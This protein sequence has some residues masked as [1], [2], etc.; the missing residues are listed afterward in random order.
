MSCSMELVEMMDAIELEEKQELQ[1]TKKLLSYYQKLCKIRT[2]EIKRLEE[3]NE[4]YF[5]AWKYYWSNGMMGKESKITMGER[6]N[7]I[8]QKLLDELEDK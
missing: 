1:K 4:E 3:E 2:E 6:D 8:Y 5:E 7:G